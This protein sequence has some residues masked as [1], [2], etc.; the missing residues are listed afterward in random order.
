MHK[1]LLEDM[2]RSIPLLTQAHQETEQRTDGIADVLTVTPGPS[3]DRLLVIAA[4]HRMTNC[5]QSQDDHQRPAETLGAPLPTQY[6][7]RGALKDSIYLVLGQSSFTYDHIHGRIGHP[8]RSGEL[9]PLR[10]GVVLR[11]VTTR[12]CLLLYVL[13]F[14]WPDRRSTFASTTT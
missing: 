7:A 13:H 8:V 10:G 5:H 12:E 14:F 9:K 11:W 1:P 3:Q 6:I 4:Q 2:H